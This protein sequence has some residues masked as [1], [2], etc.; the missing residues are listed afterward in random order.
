MVGSATHFAKGETAANSR[1]SKKGVVI[2][3]NDR[4]AKSAFTGGFCLTI[5]TPIG[6]FTIRSDGRAITSF[7]PA[8]G[9]CP[10]NPCDVI[11]ACRDQLERYF[12]GRL[13]E[14]DLPLAPAGTPFQRS[15]WDAL[16]RIGY[17][18]T[19]SYG[20]IAAAIGNPGAV[21]AVGS[22]VGANPIPV[23]IP[24]HRII[25]AD[26]SIGGFGLGLP[27]KRVLLNIEGIRL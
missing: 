13:R 25:R 18:Q 1:L 10:A 6:D 20:Q 15:V 9:D 26:G 22:A 24:C 7:L 17:G 4:N 19:A 16:R 2:T 3:T 27:A 8:E 14:F 5:D 12:A 11:L 23:I 21:R